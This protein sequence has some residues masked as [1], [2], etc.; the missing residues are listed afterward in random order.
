[1]IRLNNRQIEA[2]PH[3]K[4]LIHPYKHTGEGRTT[5][6]A[7]AV[8][9]IAI[10][11]RGNNVRFGHLMEPVLRENFKRDLLNIVDKNYGLLKKTSINNSTMSIRIDR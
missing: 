4:W 10:E 11:N 1:M 7:T 3:I 5:V 8:V 6:L 2:L 9:E